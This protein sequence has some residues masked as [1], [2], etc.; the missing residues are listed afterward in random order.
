M[1]RFDVTAELTVSDRGLWVEADTLEE[2]MQVAQEQFGTPD[3][4]QFHVADGHVSLSVH[5]N[6]HKDRSGGTNDG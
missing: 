6:R 2:A 1:T 3:A 5:P 4:W